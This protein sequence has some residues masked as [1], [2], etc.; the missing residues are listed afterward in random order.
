MPMM[1]PVRVDGLN[2]RWSAGLYQFDG[3][4]SHYYSKDNGGYRALGLDQEGGAYV[5]L[6]VAAAATH[7]LIGQPVVADEAGQDLFIQVTCLPGDHGPGALSWNI[8]ANNPTDHPI[9]TTLHR[10][11]NL[12]GLNFSDTRITLQAGE[13]RAL[14]NR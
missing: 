14:E 5:P 6:H 1:V 4:R 10:A 7:D 2:R 12:P 13:Y 9:E 11:M 3:F 8:S